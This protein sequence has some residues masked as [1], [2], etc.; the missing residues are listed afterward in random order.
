MDLQGQRLH[1]L[2]LAEPQPQQFSIAAITD[3][4]RLLAGNFTAQGQQITELVDVPQ[5]E[6]LLLTPDGR[7][8]YLLSGNQLYVYQFGTALT[9]REVVSLRSDK[10][11]ADGPLTLS[12]LA[13]EITAGAIARGST[14]VVV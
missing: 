7:L 3:D 12:L 1:H 11:T 5:A 13:G 4:G 9:L 8:L 14:D 2:A 6:Q 10:D